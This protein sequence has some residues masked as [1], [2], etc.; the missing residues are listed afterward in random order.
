MVEMSLNLS[1]LATSDDRAADVFSTSYNI[2]IYIQIN[3]HLTVMNPGTDIC[4]VPSEQCR[5]V[6]Q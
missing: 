5:G 1:I 3:F 2:K 6:T 4:N